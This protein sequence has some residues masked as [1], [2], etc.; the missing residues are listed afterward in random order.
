MRNQINDII[1]QFVSFSDRMREDVE[2]EP[3]HLRAHAIIDGLEH[4]PKGLLLRYEVIKGEDHPKRRASCAVCYEPLGLDRPHEVEDN[5]PTE[6]I[7]TENK[8]LFLALPYHAAFPEV[9]AFPCLHL[10]HS[11]CLLPWL[12]RKTTC[13]TCRFDVDPHSLTL[14]GGDAKR[15][16]VP[17]VEGVL[18][19]WV[20]DE[21]TKKFPNVKHG[22]WLS[23]SILLPQTFNLDV[24]LSIFE[25]EVYL[26]D[27]EV[28]PLGSG[29]ESD[30]STSSV[31]SFRTC[32]EGDQ[33]VF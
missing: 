9:V 15:P 7:R 19:A 24:V 16:W 3:D 23:R 11:E 10:F 28:P 18:E 4:V 22:S 2:R 5:D 8:K 14:K 26:S 17:P 30:E 32:F 27:P 21:E 33:R 12:A 25:S 6:P 1:Q 13:P 20:R 29:Y 31:G